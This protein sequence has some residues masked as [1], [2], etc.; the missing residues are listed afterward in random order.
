MPCNTL[1]WGVQQLSLY[2]AET[3]AFRCRPRCQT[4]SPEMTDR[5]LV[6]DLILHSPLAKALSAARWSTADLKAK[7]P[8]PQ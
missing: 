2:P 8:I 5:V 1:L 7:Y 4:L 6:Q 3:K